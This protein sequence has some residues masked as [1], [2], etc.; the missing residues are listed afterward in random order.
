MSY[1]AEDGDDEAKVNGCG[2]SE[3]QVWF[4]TTNDHSIAAVKDP[5][6]RKER[7]KEAFNAWHNP[8]T[9]LIDATPAD[10]IL[11]E[12]GVAH[13]YS[14]RPVYNLAEV[15][16]YE[17][18]LKSAQRGNGGDPMAASA[19]AGPGP[20]LIFV[21]DASMT[22]DPVLAQGFTFAMESAASLAA[23][24]GGAADPGWGRGSPT[25]T[26]DDSGDDDE[27]GNVTPAGC[28]LRFNPDRLR[29]ELDAR[30]YR[31]YDRLMCLL[32]ST[33]MVQALAQPESGTVSGFLSR[34]FVRPAMRLAPDF[35]KRKAFDTM[36]R[37]SLG[38]TLK[39]AAGEGN[40]AGTGSGSG[41]EEH[42]ER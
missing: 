25:A 31:R 41:G 30:H 33:E 4:A 2:R 11:M 19:A 23:S 27:D 14:I 40:R 34:N 1:P 38:L 8:V 22:V 7:L 10:D 16:D 3:R 28:S 36:M 39:S 21:G 37:Y 32:R 13:K 12:R 5:H 9:Q 20:A 26:D 35:V 15:V 17:R 6:E 18:K 24:W 29:S 42:K